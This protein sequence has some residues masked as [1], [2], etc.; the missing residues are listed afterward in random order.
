MCEQTRYQHRAL[1][2]TQVGKKRQQ[3]R[4]WS[5]GAVGAKDGA[6]RHGRQG[7]GGWLEVG[8]TGDREDGGP[9]ESK[10]IVWVWLAAASWQGLRGP[11]IRHM[12]RAS[13]SILALR[14]FFLRVGQEYR[15][16]SKIHKPEPSRLELIISWAKLA[17]N[18][19][20]HYNLITTP[21]LAYL[22]KECNPCGN[23][24]FSDMS[25]E[26]VWPPHQSEGSTREH[27]DWWGHPL[28][29]PQSD[30]ANAVK[31]DGLASLVN[32]KTTS[33]VH[34][35]SRTL[36]RHQYVEWIRREAAY[37]RSPI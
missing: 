31:P 1:Q 9:G 20:D 23:G 6:R 3:F 21:Y 19:C 5:T 15:L 26:K 18:P 28:L 8:V 25:S 29:K 35:I 36:T 4:I 33:T 32:Y 13:G 16:S 24:R 30:I 12:S 17:Y 37:H 7:R 34:S 22:R 2:I 10:G 11:A 14:F 27:D